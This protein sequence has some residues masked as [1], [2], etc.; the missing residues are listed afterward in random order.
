MWGLKNR[1]TR[2]ENPS[3]F[4]I[5]APG[6]SFREHA[7]RTYA[8]R[9]AYRIALRIRVNLPIVFRFLLFLF[10]LPVTWSYQQHMMVDSED[11]EEVSEM[12]E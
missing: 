6:A 10:T 2:K 12:E 5:K 8:L 11:E 9:S 3:P 7:I 1:I 4:E